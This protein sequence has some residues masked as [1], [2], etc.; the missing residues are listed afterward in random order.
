MTMRKIVVSRGHG[1]GFG[2]SEAGVLRM[3]QLGSIHALDATLIGE[4]WPSPSARRKRERH[5]YSK[6]STD[7]GCPRDDSILIQVLEE[8]FD[9]HKGEGSWMEIV[10]IPL[11]V[12]W[13]IDDYD[14]AEWIAEK[15]RRW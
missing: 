4:Y 8:D 12:E 5:E 14:G 11:D 13:E 7:P 6:D 2:L 1:G 9:A 3:R 10:E 15:H